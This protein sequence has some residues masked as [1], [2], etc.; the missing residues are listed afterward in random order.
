[1]EFPQYRRYKNGASFFRI[2][3]PTRFE[4]IRKLGNR[5]FVRAYEV[6][7]LPDRN[8]VNDLL[9]DYQ[10]FAE[11]VDARTYEAVRAIAVPE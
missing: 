1:M 11:N 6:K 3:S 8:L 2:D 5:W 9:F 7:I 4:E 10:S